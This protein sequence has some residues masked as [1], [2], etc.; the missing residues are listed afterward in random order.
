[1]IYE[2]APIHHALLTGLSGYIIVKDAIKCDY[3]VVEAA[4]S[5]LPI[6]NEV[7]LF[8]CDSTDGTLEMLSKFAAE[9]PKIRVVSIPWPKLPTHEEWKVDDKQRPQN[10]N[11]FW[12]KLI[13]EARVHLRYQYQL[14]LDGDEVLFPCAFDEIRRCMD[15]GGV[16]YLQRLNFWPPTSKMLVPDGWVCGTYVAKLGPTS[17]W[18]PSDEHHVDGEPE[19]RLRAT[20]YPSLLIGHYGFLRKAECFFTKSKVAQVAIHGDYDKRLTEAEEKNIDWWVL[21]TFPADL[22][23]YEGTHPDCITAWLKE[24]NRL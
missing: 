22:V 14:H 7:V 6:C 2:T 8:N 4:R 13:N 16:R 20:K 18:M 11:H 17:L 12:P 15:E 3:P 10:D 9:D 5:L 19:M 24:R 21:G 23:P 1:M